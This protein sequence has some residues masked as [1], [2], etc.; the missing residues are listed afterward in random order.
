MEKEYLTFGEAQEYARM[1]A[2]T[3]RRLRDRQLIRTKLD[4]YDNRRVLI[5]RASLD[6]ALKLGIG[7]VRR[8]NLPASV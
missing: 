5:E 3:L 4:D 7:R 8:E 1:T 6:Q 2:H